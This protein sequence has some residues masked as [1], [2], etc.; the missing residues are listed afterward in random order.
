MNHL[1]TQKINEFLFLVGLN[2]EKKKKKDPISQH[3]P[4]MHMYTCGGFV[5]M[6]GKTNT[7]FQV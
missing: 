6:F 4:H 2:R 1:F 5:L 3:L 7:V